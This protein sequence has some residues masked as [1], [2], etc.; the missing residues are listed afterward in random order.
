M[1]E[2]R[3]SSRVGQLAIAYYRALLQNELAGAHGGSGDVARTCKG[4]KAKGN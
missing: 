3:E 4:R 1:A 2:W